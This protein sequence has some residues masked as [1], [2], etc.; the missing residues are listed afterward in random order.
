MSLAQL[1]A[2][3]PPAEGFYWNLRGEAVPFRRSC[4]EAWKIDD[5]EPNNWRQHQKRVD[6]EAPDGTPPRMTLSKVVEITE[7]FGP[8]IRKVAESPKRRKR[9]K[10][11]CPKG[12]KLTRGVGCKTCLASVRRSVAHRT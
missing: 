3:P 5:R 6:A 4:P 9:V 12:H 1:F 10:K 2:L 7:L 11:R 8:E